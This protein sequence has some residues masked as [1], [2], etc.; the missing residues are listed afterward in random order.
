MRK[1]KNENGMLIVEATIVFPIMFLVIFVMIFLGNAYFQRSRVDAI[2]T[3]MAFY[4]SAQCADPLLKVVQTKG[5]VPAYGDADY[6]IQPYRYFLGELGSGAGMNKIETDVEGQIR[7]RIDKLGTGLFS[8]MKPAASSI[9]AEFNN[10][11][12]YSTFDVEVSYKIPMPIRLIGMKDYFSIKSSS[13]CEVPVSDTPE[14]IRNVDMV[15]DWVE[16][17]PAGQKAINKTQ[18]VMGKIAEFIN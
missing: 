8:L 12:V 9:N 1:I 14:F 10:A 7:T 16:S 3:E 11:F 15:E 5:G 13:K 18:E 6:E 4:G 2:I 17:T